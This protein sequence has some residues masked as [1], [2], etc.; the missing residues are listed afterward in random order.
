MRAGTRVFSGVRQVVKPP[1]RRG[2]RVTRC[3]V[4]GDGTVVLRTD[5]GAR[6]DIAQTIAPQTPHPDRVGRWA[7]PIT[8][9]ST[10]SAEWQVAEAVAAWNAGLPA[11][12]RLAPQAE[13][14]NVTTCISI[15]SS[16]R[17]TQ[18]HHT[19]EAHTISA[20]GEMAYCAIEVADY[21]AMEE[22]PAIVAHE[23]G[24]CLGLPHW[25]YRGSIMYDG[26]GGWADLPSRYDLEWLAE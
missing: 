10:L 2:N 1:K 16:P 5:G 4:K 23:L 13:P 11:D 20:D 8:Y 14:C 9:H 7:S 17:L 24:H 3:R 12:R 15:T 25:D 22:W 21:A 6:I 26:A 18:P 19:G